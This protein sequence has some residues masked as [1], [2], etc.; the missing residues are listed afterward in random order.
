MTRVHSILRTLVRRG[1]QA[2]AITGLFLFGTQAAQARGD[3]APYLEVQQVVLAELDGEGEVL[4]YTSVAAGVDARV[5]TRRVEAQISYR[6]E[7]RIAW[8]DD[9]VDE[10]VHSGLAQARIELVQDVLSLDAGAI[11]A[12]ARLDP[13][14]PAFGFSAADDRNIAEVYGGYVGPTVSTHVGPVA[15]GASYRLGYVHVDDHG[16]AGTGFP[17]GPLDRYESATSHSL[18]ASVGMDPGELPIGW[19]VAAG[20]EREDTDRLDQRYEGKYV[21]GDVVVPISPT[22]AVTG[23]IGY[24]KL[25]ASQQDVVRD[26]NG[27]PVVTPG[28]KLVADPSKPRLLA[29]DQSGLIWDVG[30]IW[31][32]SP[33]T[34]LQARAGRRYGGTTVVGTLQHQISESAALNVVVYDSVSSFGR[35]IISDISGLPTKFNVKHHGLN[36]GLGG[37]GGCIFGTEPGTGACLDDAFQSVSTFNFRSRGASLML[38]G[39]RGAWDMQVGAGYARRKYLAPDLFSINGVE[40]ESLSVQGFLGRKL[41]RTSGLDFEAYAS[42][43]DSGI[44]GNNTI[45]SSGVTATYYRSFFWD[46]LQG[47][48]SVG[49]Y[50]TDSGDGD[51]S[52]IAAAMI[53]LSYQF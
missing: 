50:S 12:R 51:D 42:W 33:R 28:G 29:Y 7:R 3:I 24:E 43:L 44:E 1:L 46:R 10:D 18:S 25:E 49:L 31:R 6:Y 9:L 11:A 8:E 2:V 22:F 13:R 45:F 36:A 38:S 21:R 14:G 40:D 15:V 53:G 39:S 27:L 19:T 41:T 5:S 16:L 26:S 47:Q 23:G 34:E 37:A 20:Y 17:G 48:A 32:P 4:T 35:S 52:A 30:V